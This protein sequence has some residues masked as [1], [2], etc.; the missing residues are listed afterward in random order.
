[1][2]VAYRYPS[3]TINGSATAAVAPFSG[4]SSALVVPL[5]RGDE[6]TARF[7]VITTTSLAVT[8]TISIDGG[9]T[10]GGTTVQSTTG[11]V[12]PRSTSLTPAAGTI[13]EIDVRGVTH[14]K[15]TRDAGSGTVAFSATEAIG[16]SASAGVAA[17]KE[18]PENIALIRTGA[19]DATV[20]VTFWDGDGATV[21]VDGAD[22]KQLTIS[23]TA[24]SLDK[25]LVD[26]SVTGGVPSGAAGGM[27]LVEPTSA[28]GVA[29]NTGGSDDGTGSNG[30]KGATYAPTASSVLRLSAG[31]SLVFGV[32]G[33]S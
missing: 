13:L 30:L 20:R 14:I 6:G 23:S 27:I 11:A 26:A 1:M 22:S 24:K 2:E 17:A 18:K 8:F 12:F 19:S 7:Q 4:T 9:T 10:Y 16:A 21:V 33:L 3:L 28:S 32:G 5:V 29:V 25:F 15:I 31:D